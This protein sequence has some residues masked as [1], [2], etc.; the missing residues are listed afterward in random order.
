MPHS[1]HRVFNQMTRQY[2]GNSITPTSTPPNTKGKGKVTKEEVN[3]VEDEEDDEMDEEED[4][5]DDDDDDDDV[6][7]VQFPGSPLSD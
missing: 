4:D 2:S 5:G 1:F 7:Q 6:S 3:E